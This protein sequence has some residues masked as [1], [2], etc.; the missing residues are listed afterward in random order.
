MAGELGF[1]AGMSQGVAEGVK[2][3]LSTRQLLID[4]AN[5]QRLYNAQNINA[6]ANL[7]DKGGTD[8]AD[9]QKGYLGLL[10][11]KTAKAAP[12]STDQKSTP[13]NPQQS[14]L[15]GY[16][17]SSEVSPSGQYNTSNN[18][19]P[20]GPQSQSS[21]GLLSGFPSQEEVAQ[22]QR[23]AMRF[24]SAQR[25]A[26]TTPMMERIKDY[27]KLNTPS[28]AQAY[29]QG[30][31]TLRNTQLQQYNTSK[32]S[33]DSDPIVKNMSGVGLAYRKIM[34]AKNNPTSLNSIFFNLYQLEN[35]GSVAST[36]A[37]ALKE[38]PDY[39]QSLKDRIKLSTTGQMTDKSFQDIKRT[40]T[41]VYQASRE[42]QQG[43]SGKYQ[44]LGR[45]TGAGSAF[46]REPQYGQTDEMAKQFT[47]GAPPYRS[48]ISQ[49]Y[50]DAKGLLSGP[51]PPPKM[52]EVRDGY[53]FTGGH[54]GQKSSWKKVR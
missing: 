30:S 53:K 37:E 16:S 47:S 44:K 54:P 52:G 2:S 24:P 45:V 28:G 5:K 41:G 38:N 40:A 9:A 22:T 23:Y 3:Y 35:P 20:S 27:S 34:E 6:Y 1:L 46:A 43:V 4:N 32:G 36:P 51:P 13:M 18:L 17:P 10:G 12:Y 7:I 50:Q 42:A 39:F 19:A 15:E 33:F 48:G 31:A 21:S 49:T 25:E 26:V 11:G 14:P 8:I 29:K